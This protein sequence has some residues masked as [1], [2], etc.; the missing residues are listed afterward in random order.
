FKISVRTVA[1][2]LFLPLLSP[3][4]SRAMG[5]LDRS[6]GVGGISAIR[7]YKIFVQP[8]NRIL[9]VDSGVGDIFLKRYNEDGSVDTSFSG[10]S[11]TRVWQGSFGKIRLQPDNKILVS[12]GSGF[13]IALNSFDSSTDP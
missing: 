8:D 1:F 6:F 10:G 11:P 13:L 12:G 4:I 2:L 5:V 3:A 7:T 9:V